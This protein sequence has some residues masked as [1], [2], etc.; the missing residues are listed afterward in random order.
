L[1]H[2]QLQAEPSEAVERAF[3]ERYPGVKANVV[4]SASQVAFQRLSQDARA[5]VAQ[6]DV[7][8]STDTSHFTALKRQDRLLPYRPRNAEGMIG[9]ARDA[10]DPDGHYQITY[11]ALYL[12]ARRTDRVP[13]AEAPRSWRDLTDARWRDQLAVG[14]PATAAPSA[15][16]AWRCARCTAGTTS[17]RWSGTGRRSA[18]R[19]A[20]R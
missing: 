6:C 14:H 10:A 20:T 9:A 2:G 17:G 15:R 1:V 8:S 19:L 12:L 11:L 18:A 13:E 16:G 3:A 5:R 4:R 7:F